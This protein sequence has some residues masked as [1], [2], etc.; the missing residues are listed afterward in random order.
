MGVGRP[1]GVRGRGTGRAEVCSSEEVRLDRRRQNWLTQDAADADILVFLFCEWPAKL[2]ANTVGRTGSDELAAVLALAVVRALARVE[3][4]HA[5]LVRT[6]GGTHSARRVRQR[7]PCTCRVSPGA[8]LARD[9]INR[10]SHRRLTT[11][12]VAN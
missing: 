7:A 3:A 10:G 4:Q 2:P 6:C 5:Q 11:T 1:G 8:V 12:T 9:L